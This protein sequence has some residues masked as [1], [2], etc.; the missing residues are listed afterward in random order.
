MNTQKTVTYLKVVSNTLLNQ[1]H[2]VLE[3]LAP[4]TL[5]LILPGNFV[6]VLVEDSPPT[7]L[8]RPFSVHSVDYASN[9]F[10]LL[11]QVKGPGTSR[12]SRLK[13][14]EQVNVM[15]PLGNSFSLPMSPE[16]LLVG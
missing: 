6:Q 16:I 10:R 11:V 5:P 7:F 9:T 1:R 3:L 8:R 14:G 4:E 12:L 2:F 13:A 15:F